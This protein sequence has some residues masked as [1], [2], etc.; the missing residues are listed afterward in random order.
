MNL[1]PKDVAEDLNVS[2]GTVKKLLT[3]GEL[4]G[5]RVGRLWRIMPHSLE[6]F[7]QRPSGG[8]RFNPIGSDGK[9]QRGR[10]TKVID[11]FTEEQESN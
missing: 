3:S 11:T 6:E 7:K 2:L 8:Q 10:P 4:V 9:R 1:K 5:F